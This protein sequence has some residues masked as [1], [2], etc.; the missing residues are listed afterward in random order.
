MN[1]NYTDNEFKFENFR[2]CRDTYISS[3]PQCRPSRLNYSIQG[4]SNLVIN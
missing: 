4:V 1:A 2:N 3:L